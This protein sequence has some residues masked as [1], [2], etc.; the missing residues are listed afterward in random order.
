MSNAFLA[1]LEEFAGKNNNTV[2]PECSSIQIHRKK[3]IEEPED[4]FD[5]TKLDT[6]ATGRRNRG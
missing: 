3:K 6:I 4:D 5:D 1:D 2:L